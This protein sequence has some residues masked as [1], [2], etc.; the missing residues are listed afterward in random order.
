[1]N[2]NEG[3]S[4]GSLL[5]RIAIVMLITAVSA[6]L[7]LLFFQQDL[8]V[9]REVLKYALFAALGLV[10][11]FSAR[12]LLATQTFYLRLFSGFIALIAAL[13]M[14]NLASRGL[15]G[16]D[17]LRL[18]L[19]ATPWD[20]GLSLGVS[21]AAC[22]LALLA[23]TRPRPIMVEPRQAAPTPAAPES[24]P[25]EARPTVEQPR[26]SPPR[27]AA[28]P[29]LITTLETWRAGA[30]AQLARLVPGRGP[31]GTR[32]RKLAEK[33]GRSKPGQWGARRSRSVTLSGL[34]EHVCPY[35]LDLV[36]KNDRRGVKI[37]KVCKTWHHADCWAITG[38]CQVPHQYV[39]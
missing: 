18:D 39:H 23:W 14:L 4:L 13:V 10:A 21:A 26:L 33:P 9:S 25:Q 3:S 5:E 35:C 30:A 12:Y 2:L 36:R 24:A 22:W 17:L 6:L 15:V 31:A 11:G 27:R 20:G 28:S 7:F 8:Q 32:K 38:V 34:T 1:M 37:C 29:P 19:S 16:L